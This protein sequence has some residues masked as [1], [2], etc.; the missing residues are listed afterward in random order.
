MEIVNGPD[1]TDLK[2]EAELA[3][4]SD[5]DAAS[6]REGESALGSVVRGLV[7]TLD[8]ITFFT[9]ARRRRA[10]GRC[11]RARLRWTPPRR[12]TATSRAGS[13]APR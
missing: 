1:G 4:L 13:S 10:R 5:E 3:E 8:L 6:F 9:A 7:E 12:S 2:L 11:A